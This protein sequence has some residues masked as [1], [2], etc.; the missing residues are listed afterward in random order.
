MIVPT[1][2]HVILTAVSEAT[3][4]FSS[5]RG[6]DY[7]NLF[8]VALDGTNLSRLTQGVSNF[9]AAGWSPN[10]NWE[11][12]TMNADGNDPRNLTNDPAG[13]QYPFI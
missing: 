12:Y 13:D 7:S 5:N 11:I 6:G 1:I 2:T 4:L 8:T 10:G 9:F 3:L